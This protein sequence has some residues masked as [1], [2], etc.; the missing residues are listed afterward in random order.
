MLIK[1][2]QG[3]GSQLINYLIRHVTEIGFKRVSLLTVP[4]E[5]KPLYEHTV[6]FYEK[7]GFIV[8]KRYSEIWGSGAIE[9]SKNL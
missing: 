9:M 8:S 6:K 1:R 3:L 2:G 5:V 4:P 7:H